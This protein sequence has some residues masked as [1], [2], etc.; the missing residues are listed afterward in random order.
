LRSPERMSTSSS[1]ELD[2]AAGGRARRT[3][4]VPSG[5][6]G[7]NPRITCR[8]LLETL[9]R[10]TDPPTDLLT[11]RPTRVEGAPL[12]S[13]GGFLSVCTTTR[14]LPA[15]APERITAANSLCRVSRCAGASTTGRSSGGE[16]GAALTTAC[17]DD[18]PA[19]A[20][21]H[22]QSETVN[23]CAPPVVRL[24]RPLSLAHGKHSLALRWINEVSTP[25]DWP[26]FALNCHVMRFDPAQHRHLL[27]GDCSRL[28][29]TN[30]QVKRADSAQPPRDTLTTTDPCPP[31]LG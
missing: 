2:V 24:K 1:A 23:S 4:W 27:L 6:A 29:R 28:R 17:R 15:R 22:A 30:G 25:T 26:L 21:A 14:V 18:G 5:R 20:G 19:G 9:C 10:T 7:T 3:T 8:S 11:M 12:L 16:L 13:K 31:R